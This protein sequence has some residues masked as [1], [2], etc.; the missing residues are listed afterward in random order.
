MITDLEEVAGIL[1]RL[2]AGRREYAAARGNPGVNRDLLLH[3]AEA[4]ENAANCIDGTASWRGLVAA[5]APSWRWSEF[6]EHDPTPGPEE[7]L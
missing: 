6:G 3:E 7:R 5:Y 4:L 1:R 2:A